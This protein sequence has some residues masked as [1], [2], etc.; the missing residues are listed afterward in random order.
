MAD[1]RVFNSPGSGLSMLIHSKPS[2]LPHGNLARKDHGRSPHKPLQQ[3]QSKRTH[4]KPESHPKP[5]GDASLH[6]AP[7]PPPETATLQAEQQS[8]S[9]YMNAHQPGHT[10]AG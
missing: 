1:L 5:D 4:T 2:S 3:Q 8:L 7:T 9:A 6:D 10:E